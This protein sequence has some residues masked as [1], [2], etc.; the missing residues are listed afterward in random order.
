LQ[1]NGAPI[2]GVVGGMER[3]T[4]GRNKQKMLIWHG[5]EKINNARGRGLTAKRQ[6]DVKMAKALNR[7]FSKVSIYPHGHSTWK[8]VPCCEWL[9]KCKLKPQWDRTSCPLDGYKFKKWK[10]TSRVG[11]MRTN[12]EPC[13]LL[14][15][16]E[17]GSVTVEDRSFLQRN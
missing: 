7:H 12:K 8:N 4:A 17:N 16:V 15:W 11:G 1:R 6:R 9:G 3:F 14:V 5:E 10:V 13:A 2:R